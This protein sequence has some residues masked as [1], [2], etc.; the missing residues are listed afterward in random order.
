MLK[1]NQ[2]DPIIAENLIIIPAPFEKKIEF[3]TRTFGLGSYIFHCPFNL[4]E[5]HTY[6]DYNH[7]E[8]NL[9]GSH[10][11]QL[12]LEERG[13]YKHINSKNFIT[14]QLC[15]KHFRQNKILVNRK[16]VNSL[17]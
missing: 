11:A 1:K 13:K 5:I 6:C 16:N 4:V 8:K 9:L 17:V 3:V 14:G 10:D 12:T 15:N 2:P 7:N